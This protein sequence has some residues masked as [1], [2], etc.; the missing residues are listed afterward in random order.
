MAL[1]S[2]LSMAVGNGVVPGDARDPG[3]L[4]DGMLL[5]AIS[6]SLRAA[7]SN[8]VLLQAAAMLAPPHTTVVTYAGLGDLPHFN[9][10]LDTDDPPGPVAALREAV[11]RADGLLISSPEYAHGIAGSM[12]NALDWLVRSVEFPS[13][14]V[15]VLNAAPR[16]THALAQMREILTTMSADLVS[17][18][19]ITV[20]LGGRSLGAAAIA[21]D[22]SLAEPLRAAMLRF[23]GSIARKRTGAAASPGFDL[24][25]EEDGW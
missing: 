11:G 19:S 4:W 17:D 20:P 10:D 1:R 2:G 7:S 6:G 3:R 9:P 24:A 14:P 13:K 23:V 15:A 21:A 18:A 5:L 16:A 25:S 8:T 12:K 22:P